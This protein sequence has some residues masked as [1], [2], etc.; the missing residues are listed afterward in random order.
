MKQT[1]EIH[2][3]GVCEN[4]NV[5]VAF[6]NILR[7]SQV[8]ENDNYNKQVLNIKCG[9]EVCYQ[10][11]GNEQKISIKNSQ[12]AH[13]HIQGECMAARSPPCWPEFRWMC[14]LEVKCFL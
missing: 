8:L 14:S 2:S 1:S 11:Q 4:G 10:K 9:Y 12:L 7:E 6:Q 5:T 3:L 13:Y